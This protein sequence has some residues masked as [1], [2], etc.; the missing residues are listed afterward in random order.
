MKKPDKKL[1]A[2]ETLKILDNQWADIK[3]IMNLGYLGYNRSLDV[4]KS[5]RENLKKDGYTTPN[6][7]V[8]M[9]KVI[10]YFNINISYL[11][12]VAKI[13]KEGEF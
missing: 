9:D 11:K 1:S 4:M 6:K 2:T 8:P 12:K 3:D 7:L 13:K 5:I 10:E